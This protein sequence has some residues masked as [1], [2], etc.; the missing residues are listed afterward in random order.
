[1]PKATFFPKQSPKD[2][3][4]AL[5]ALVR[6]WLDQSPNEAQDRATLFAFI[7]RA[8]QSAPAGEETD[9]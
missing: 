5:S 6:L 7:G 9:A 3:K 1:M 2:F 8:G 4:A